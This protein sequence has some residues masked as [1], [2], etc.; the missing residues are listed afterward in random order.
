MP[1][2]T[3][4]R[5]VVVTDAFC[6]PDHTARIVAS[7]ML[8]AVLCC[9]PTHLCWQVA[10]ARFVPIQR[11]PCPQRVR[12]RRVKCCP[13]WAELTQL[14]QRHAFLKRLCNRIAPEAAALFAWCAAQQRTA[15]QVGKCSTAG[16]GAAALLPTP[17]MSTHEP[18]TPPGR[19]A[20]S[21]ALMFLPP[22]PLPSSRWWCP[23]SRHTS[24]LPQH[25]RTEAPA[26][27]TTHRQTFTPPCFSCCTQ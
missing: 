25:T 8:C 7:S 15:G 11:A 19:P 4:P 12:S 14:P 9:V 5:T 20:A 16:F 26:T 10:A 21:P 24:L 17:A 27:H 6:D 22:P 23:H 3:V 2:R 13:R 18:S 1:A